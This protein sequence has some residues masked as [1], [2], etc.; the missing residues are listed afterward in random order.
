MIR[1]LYTAVSGMISQEAKQEVISNNL[2]NTETTGFKSDNLVLKKFNDVLIENCDKISGGKN[3]PNVIGSMSF[4][5][6]IDGTYTDFTQGVLQSTNSATD[7]AVEGK[8]FFTVA[9]TDGLG[10]SR[11]YYTRDGHF[12]VDM[13]GYL[14]TD[15][16]DQVLGVNSKTNKIEPIRV[17]NSNIDTDSDGNITL[18]GKVAYKFNM[19]DFNDY[20]ALKKVGD[21]LYDGVNPVKMTTTPVKQKYL[22][23][24]NVDSATE[25]VNMMTVVRSYESDQKVIANMDEML[26]K[27]VNDVGTVR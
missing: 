17:N 19:M 20:G 14:V 2:S 16:G 12:H 6:K 7:F 5:T 25:I 4:G 15:S 13:R 22:E 18:D 1:G 23:G 21:N 10:N 26:G 8:G 9:K 27:A 11:D 24:S 3:V